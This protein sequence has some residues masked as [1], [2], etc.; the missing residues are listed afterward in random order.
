L[1][2][3]AA[4]PD[5][6]QDA[7]LSGVK[8]LTRSSIRPRRLFAEAAPKP[9]AAPQIPTEEE[10][11]DDECHA[12][13]EVVHKDSKSP[14]TPQSPEFPRAPGG[15]R[16][17][18]S[19]ARYGGE[20]DVT[21][22]ATAIIS[23]NKRKRASPFDHWLRQKPTP[24]ETGSQGSSPTKRELRSGSPSAPAPKKTRSTRAVAESQSA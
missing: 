5:L 15:T 8:S 18:R 1:G 14:Y 13:A 2:L 24:D 20:L 11:T 16:N 10:A 17:L 19:A 3:F 22:T 6:L 23:D 9:H 12:E 21:P 4:R 7:D